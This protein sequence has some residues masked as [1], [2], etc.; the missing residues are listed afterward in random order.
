[1]S[2]FRHPSALVGGGQ[3][4]DKGNLKVK[5]FTLIEV[6]VAMVILAI[7]LGGALLL[8]QNSARATLHLK[9]KIAAHEAAETVLSNL[10]LGILAPPAPDAAQTGQ[11][12]LLGQ[13]WFWSAE[14]DPAQ[15]QT[16]HQHYQRVLINVRSNTNRAPL[17]NLVGFAPAA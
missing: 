1:M 4:P 16:D 11:D 15:I 7:G 17:E 5:G 9:E 8:L 12:D 10:Q 13:R 2:E 3:R 14:T 6:L